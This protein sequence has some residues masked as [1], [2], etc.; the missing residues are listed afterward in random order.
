MGDETGPVAAGFDQCDLAARSR[1][2]KFDYEALERTFSTCDLTLTCAP[3][4]LREIP[5]T[6]LQSSQREAIDNLCP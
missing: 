2:R 3:H 5:L 1:R 6:Q 4:F